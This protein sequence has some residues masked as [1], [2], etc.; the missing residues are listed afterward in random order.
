MPGSAIIIS[1]LSMLLLVLET[2][3]LGMNAGINI[4]TSYREKKA[5]AVTE[6][7]AKAE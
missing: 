7:P 3:A 6:S 5:C 2:R 1:R 4:R